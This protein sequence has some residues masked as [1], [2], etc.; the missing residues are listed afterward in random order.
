LDA[1]TNDLDGFLHPRPG[2][3]M[4]MSYARADLAPAIMGCQAHPPMDGRALTVL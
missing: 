4:G 2:N 1:Y 3:T